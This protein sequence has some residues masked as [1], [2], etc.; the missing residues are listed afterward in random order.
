MAQC[1]VKTDFSHPLTFPLCALWA[2]LSPPREKFHAT[3]NSTKSHGR[4]GGWLYVAE[5]VHRI[6]NE[7]TS[8]IASMRLAAARSSST[9]AK[10]AL[11]R[12]AGQL[13]AFATAH[14]V[15]QPP[16]SGGLVDLS[17]SLTRLCKAVT[18]PVYRSAGCLCR[19]RFPGRCCSRPLAAGAP[20]SLSGADHECRS[21]CFRD[22]RRTDQSVVTLAAGQVAC[23][24][25][26]NG[27]G[28][29]AFT[30]GLAPS[31]STRCR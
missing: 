1:V 2:G 16:L 22:G 28:P 13:G 17:D 25:S 5:I 24:V 8:A 12:A 31:S 30:P 21:S 27:T 9:E 6:G 10:A 15:M 26:D 20:S 23:E 11:D 18:R 14:R 29:A 4:D 7:Y 3:A 19:W